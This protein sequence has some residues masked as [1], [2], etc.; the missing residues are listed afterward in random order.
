VA[1]STA[2]ISSVAPTSGRLSGP[3][4]PMPLSLPSSTGL[5]SAEMASVAGARP[6]MNS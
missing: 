6:V 4:G 3:P 5:L 1:A 2:N